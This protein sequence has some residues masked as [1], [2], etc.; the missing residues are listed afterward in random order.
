MKGLS[1]NALKIIEQ[2]STSIG[3]IFATIKM[4]ISNIIQLLKATIKEY[5]SLRSILTGV[6]SMIR[7]AWK[8]I[9]AS[10]SVWITLFKG[11][12]EI[13]LFIL[14]RPAEMTM[15][16]LF[17]FLESRGINISKSWKNALKQG[18]VTGTG[19]AGIIYVTGK[20]HSAEEEQYIQDLKNF[21]KGEFA[22]DPGTIATQLEQE[23]KKI[24]INQNDVIWSVN[25]NRAEPVYA[26]TDSTFAAHVDFMNP[27]LPPIYDIS[28]AITDTVAM[29]KVRTDSLSPEFVGYTFKLYNPN[30]YDNSNLSED[31]D[32]NNMYITANKKDVTSLIVNYKEK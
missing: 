25:T 2:L 20:M 5:P 23:G 1:P 7:G 3:N 24:N 22:K 9:S 30:L 17:K 28:D 16:A 10:L 14:T 11:L 32:W 31:L 18:A 29:Y 26:S 19:L 4:W 8:L 21:Y 27:D 13:V 6:L 12:G 15:E